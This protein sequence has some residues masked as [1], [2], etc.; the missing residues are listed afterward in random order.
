PVDRVDQRV[1]LTLAVVWREDDE[2]LR[3]LTAGALELQLAHLADRELRHHRL[4]EA[5]EGRVPAARAVA[6]V[7]LGRLRE[8]VPVV[9][10][11]PVAAGAHAVREP[12]AHDAPRRA[13]ALPREQAGARVLLGFE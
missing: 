4:G 12:A 9:E 3:L 1:T 10:Q 11:P 7:D 2:H 5:R 6:G 13:R 8:R